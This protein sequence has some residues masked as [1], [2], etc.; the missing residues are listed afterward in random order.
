[1]AMTI[2]DRSI[3]HPV[4]QTPPR[5]RMLRVTDVAELLDLPERRVYI[6]AREGVLPHVR[7]GRSIR[8]NEAALLAWLEAGGSTY[9][10]EAQ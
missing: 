2:V 6:L 7:L 3:A 8:F 4:E 5:P 1:M 10:A 9:P